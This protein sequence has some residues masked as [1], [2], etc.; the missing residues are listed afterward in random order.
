MENKKMTRADLIALGVILFVTLVLAFVYLGDHKGVHTPYRTNGINDRFVIELEKSEKIAA[1][2]YFGTMSVESYLETIMFSLEY[3]DDGESWQE[4]RFKV[5]PMDVYSVL[6]WRQSRFN[7][8]ITAKY[9]RFT[10]ETDDYIL[11]ELG[12]RREDGSFAKVRS[13][14][15]TYAGA[16]ALVDEQEL[17]PESANVLNSAYFDEIY[18]A[19]TAY[20]HINY[21]PYYEVTHPPL[22]KLIMSVGIRIFG[23]T[24][25]GWRFMGALVG[26]LMVVPFYLLLR[27]LLKSTLYAS[28]GTV[29]FAFDFMRFSLTRMAT[30]DS[31]PMFFVLFMYYFMLRFCELASAYADGEKASLKEMSCWLA[32]S[33]ICMGLACACK[34]TA[35]FAAV[36]LAIIFAFVMITSARRFRKRTKK[37]PLA[38]AAKCGAWCVLWFII[39]PAMIYTLSYRPIA[40]IDGV[41]PVKA[42]LDNTKVMFEYH[43]GLVDEHAFASRWYSWPVVYRPLWAYQAPIGTLEEGKI[44]AISIFPN[45]II[46]W[47][48]IG[49]V[50]FTLAWSFIN[51]DKVGA[52]LLVGFFSQYIPWIFISRLTYIYHYFGAYIFGIM[53]LT[54][55]VKQIVLMLDGRVKFIKYLPYAL[56]GVSVVMFVMFYP[57]LTGVPVSQDYAEFLSW[58]DSWVFFAK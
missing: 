28:C 21:M 32:L 50:V 18:H 47:L 40:A 22:G 58:L 48:V 39:I 6:Y 31:Y 51:R 43:T 13:I 8:P 41:S 2:D 23:L 24:P 53:L 15:G 38:A 17:L 4:Y 30:I 56:S 3:S 34:W 5:C 16:E 29:I 11:F 49:A 55:T 10:A 46:S 20:E 25:F 42:M 36:G 35:P 52:F 33:G 57:V 27:R 44:G 45:P 19:R 1:V 26:A 12:F 9:W 7:E 37:S 54:Y 14:S